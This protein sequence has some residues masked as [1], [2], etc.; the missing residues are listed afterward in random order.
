MAKE[1]ISLEA[2]P[3]DQRLCRL[4]RAGGRVIKMLLYGEGDRRSERN[5]SV[6]E[7]EAKNRDCAAHEWRY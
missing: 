3:A 6:L 4:C 7:N 5:G 2:K 1:S